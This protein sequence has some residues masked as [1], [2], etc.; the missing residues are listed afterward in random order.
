MR[1]VAVGMALAGVIAVGG[2]NKA[3]DRGTTNI[4]GRGLRCRHPPAPP[5]PTQSH[6]G[7]TTK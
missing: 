3:I 6:R 1:G 4:L 5:Q 2:M 7:T